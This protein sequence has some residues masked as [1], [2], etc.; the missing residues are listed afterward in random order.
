MRGRLRVSAGDTLDGLAKAGVH[1]ALHYACA[2]KT[3]EQ[4]NEIVSSMMTHASD[5]PM[6]A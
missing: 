3:P 5:D 1:V 2:E 6:S 4:T